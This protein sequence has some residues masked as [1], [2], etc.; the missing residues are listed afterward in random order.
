L[1]TG[2]GSRANVHLTLA[3]A[4]YDH[5]RDLVSGLV[6]VEGIDLTC[7]GFSV[8]ETFFRFARFRE[9]DISEFSLGKYASIRASGDDSIVAIPVFPSRCFRHSAIFVRADGPVDDPT[10]LAGGRIGVPEWTQ[11]ATIWARGLLQHTYGIDLGSV[12]WFQGGTNEPGRVEGI[13]LASPRGFS[14][15]PVRDRSLN[16][17]LVAGDLDAVIA[18]HPPAAFEQRTR[19]VV[20]LFT[21]Y[22]SVEEQYYRDTSIFPI[23]HV[24]ALRAQVLH[25]YPWAAM[26]LYTAFR[27]AKRLSLIRA[28][29]GNAPRYPIPW[30]FANAERAEEILGIDFWPYGLE[31]NRATLDAFLGFAHEQGVCAT[32]LAPEDL[33]PEQVTAEY[34]I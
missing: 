34:R 24:V 1:N 13:E 32:R 11:T 29:D 25:E 3:I 8:E 5:V 22:R 26:N 28:I 7:L 30:S 10:S 15:T 31:R 18:A 20:R 12:E 16:D 27:E 21:D 4:D 33:F 14:L 19:C 9:W 17:M 6:P 23:M 2:N